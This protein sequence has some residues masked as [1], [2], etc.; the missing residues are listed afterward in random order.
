MTAVSFVDTNIW[1]YAHLRT[2]NEPKHPIALAFVKKLKNGRISPQ[3]VAEYYSVMLK[4][5]KD[6]AWI[7]T[8]LSAILGYTRLQALDAS[9][10]HRALAVRREHRIRE[11]ALDLCHNICGSKVLEM[12]Q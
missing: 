9:V 10:I 12:G 1:I 5:G 3:V 7:Q 6:D 2:P 4:N 11:I 8:N